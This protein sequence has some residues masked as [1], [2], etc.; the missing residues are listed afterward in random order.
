MCRYIAKNIVASRIC[1]ECEVY[2]S[3]AIGVEQPFS[4]EV[5][6]DNLFGERFDKVL[7]EYVS[8]Y[9]NLSP[10][11]IIEKLD[12]KNIDYVSLDMGNIYGENFEG[13]EQPWEVLDIE[14]MSSIKNK[15]IEM[16]EL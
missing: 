16:L 15:Y 10:R 12:L 8:S 2:I 7:S 11:G 9:F 4:L 5:V 6:T 3:Y 14:F 13:V 1:S